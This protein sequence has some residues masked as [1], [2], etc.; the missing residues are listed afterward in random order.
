MLLFLQRRHLGLMMCTRLLLLR[1]VDEL[2]VLWKLGNIGKTRWIGNDTTRFGSKHQHFDGKSKIR[3]F[4]ISMNVCAYSVQSVNS[5]YRYRN[6]KPWKSQKC[7][8][9]PAVR[10][11][12]LPSLLLNPQSLRAKQDT[13]DRRWRTNF[14]Q[15]DPFEQHWVAN[16]TITEIEGTRKACLLSYRW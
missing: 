4:L 8:G 11:C 12:E 7:S 2:K 1:F 3:L 15:K 5:N 14:L 13:W 16:P 6:P 9:D 10:A